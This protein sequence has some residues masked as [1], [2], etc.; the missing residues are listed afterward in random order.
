MTLIPTIRPMTRS[1][2]FDLVAMAGREGWNPGLHDAEAFWACDPKAFIA[3]ELD[4]RIIGGGA[5]TAYGDQYGFMGLFIMQPD[6]RHQGLGAQ[7]W[8]ARRDRLVARLRPGATIGMDGVFEMADWYARGGFVLSHR[9]LR[10]RMDVPAGFAAEQ[11][12]AELVA[13]AD[14]PFETLAAYD[15]TCFAGPRAAFLKAW[16][17]LPEHHG[18]GQVR[19]GRL[20]G[21]GVVRRCGEGCKI[22]PLFADDAA[23]AEALFQA[24]AERAAGGP[25]FLDAA[26]NHPD[27][28]ALVA[29]HGLSEAFG[30][31]R[32][33]LGPVPDIDHAR[34]FGVTTFELG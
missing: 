6:F 28:Q 32:M 7:L 29:R 8:R 23:G 16:T 11:T 2:A 22:G 3:A 24:L 19:D 12:G 33:Y 14:V 15:R 27:A 1:E 20:A 13:L 10:Y 4:G 9:N 25:L 21:Y 31:A 26:E 18:L 17:R 30:C 5:V 34:V